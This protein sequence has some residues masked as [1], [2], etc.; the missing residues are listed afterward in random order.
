L[1]KYIFFGIFQ[2]RTYHIP[3]GGIR[4]PVS[5]ILLSEAKS[6]IYVDGT[7][8][9]VPAGLLMLMHYLLQNPRQWLTVHDFRRDLWGEG[10]FTD[11]NIRG[12]FEALREKL[13]EVTPQIL[14]RIGPAGYR[15][16]ISTAVCWEVRDD[17][18]ASDGGVDDHAGIISVSGL[19]SYIS[20]RS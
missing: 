17:E 3:K 7:P 18:P 8:V 9:K 16:H 11:Q 5:E 15:L 19:S 4:M 20:I 1:L 13:R 12:M 14:V 6:C 2:Q 10:T